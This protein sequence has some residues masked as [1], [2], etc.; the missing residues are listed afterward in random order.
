MFQA[1]LFHREGG[2]KALHGET[3]EAVKVRVEQICKKFK[4]AYIASTIIH[5]IEHCPA[6]R[7]RVYPFAWDETFHHLSTED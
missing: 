7:P 6:G 5:E 3:P 1:T 2:T 4:N